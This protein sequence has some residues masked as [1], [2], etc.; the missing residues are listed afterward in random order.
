MQP[1]GIFSL[2]AVTLVSAGVAQDSPIRT[3]TA[4]ESVTITRPSVIGY[5]PPITQAE[6]DSDEGWG[7][8]LAH[9]EFAL[10]D[11]RK[12][13][14]RDSV[15]VHLVFATTL[16]LLQPGTAPAVLNLGAGDSILGVILVGLGRD[17][18]RVN[19]KI[20]P[21]ALIPMLGQASATYFAK[22]EC[23]PFRD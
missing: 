5:F 9:L 21:S 15:D 18:Q 11:A 16:V 14:P 10:D 22:P 8:A 2:L 4:V 17:L 23:D 13:L 7:S 20:G 19:S 6:V 3:R 12:C 1:V